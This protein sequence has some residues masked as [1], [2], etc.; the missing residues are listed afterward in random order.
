MQCDHPQLRNEDKIQLLLSVMCGRDNQ[1]KGGQVTSGW[2]EQ[3]EYSCYEFKCVAPEAHLLKSSPLIP[4]NVTIFG[5][6]IYK[7]VV[8]SK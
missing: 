4:Q 1:H 5:D 6:S 7:E 8:T 3:P 2:N